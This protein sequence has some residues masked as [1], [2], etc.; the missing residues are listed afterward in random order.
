MDD[1]SNGPGAWADGSD[2]ENRDADNAH[3]VCNTAASKDD[4]TRDD[5]FIGVTNHGGPAKEESIRG[6]HRIEHIL[7]NVD[8]IQGLLEVNPLDHTQ[9]T[10]FAGGAWTG[11]ALH[12]DMCVVGLTP[13]V[14]EVKTLCTGVTPSHWKDRTRWLIAEVCFKHTVC[15]MKQLRVAWPANDAYISFCVLIIG[16]SMMHIYIYTCN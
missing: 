14:A 4:P 3:P 7:G 10:D 16:I 12:C 13:F 1:D 15:G 9:I 6:V 11:T 8:M 2:V 5:L